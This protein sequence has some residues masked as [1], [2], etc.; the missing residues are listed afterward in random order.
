LKKFDK[1]R[2]EQRPSI[3]TGI[4]L[5]WVFMASIATE[6][7]HPA[8]ANLG[9]YA[10]V[11]VISLGVSG[12]IG[13][14]IS[15]FERKQEEIARPQRFIDYLWQNASLS[16]GNLIETD[17]AFKADEC[18]KASL[19]S[20]R[21]SEEDDREI[22]RASKDRD[23]EEIKKTREEVEKRFKQAQETFYEAYD[24]ISPYSAKFGGLKKRSFKAYATRTTLE[25]A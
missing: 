6:L 3:F 15:F 22:G 2:N 13:E 25:A 14:T 8:F 11:M 4:T 1:E 16:I 18:M 19:D 23:P 10:V 7:Y 17:L 21:F 20:I 9:G 5:A 12:V 24:A